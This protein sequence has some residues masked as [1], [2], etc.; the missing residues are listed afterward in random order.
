MDLQKLDEWKH[1]SCDVKRE[2]DKRWQ[3]PS[4]FFFSQG[5]AL[6]LAAGYFADDRLV[7]KARGGVAVKHRHRIHLA[8]FGQLMA[9]FEYFLKDFVAAVVDSTSIF[10]EQIKKAKWIDVDVDRILALRNIVQP[11][12][13]T[14]LLH[15]TLGWYDPEN[16]NNRYTDLFQYQ[17]LLCS[18]IPELN[19]LWVLRHS[20]AHNAGLVTANDAGRM[21]LCNL[22]NSVVDIDATLISEAFSFLGAIAYRIAEN[23]GDRVV[24]KWLQSQANQ[25]PDYKR[26]SHTYTWLK[27]LATCIRSRTKDLPKITK[28]SYTKDFTR[29]IQNQNA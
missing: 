17:P 6:V 8:L 23:V 24:L 29:A 3:S 1:D 2:E 26:D 5:K 14:F 22:S 11:S 18:E 7:S 13:G 27:L 20:V 12:T 16:V 4:S 9:S 28:S 10:D 19:R 25:G 21:G 15:P